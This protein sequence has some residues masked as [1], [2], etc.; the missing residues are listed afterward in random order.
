MVLLRE[1]LEIHNIKPTDITG[2]I[3][4]SVVPE[5]TDNVNTAL[6]KVTGCNVIAVGPG[7]K[8]GLSIVIDNPVQILRRE[9]WQ[10]LR[11]TVIR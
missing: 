2:A 7:V 6:K 4:A 5:I 11:D 1:I 3:T 9:P 8:T 10:P